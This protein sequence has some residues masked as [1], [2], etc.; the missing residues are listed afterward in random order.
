MIVAPISDMA[1]IKPSK[2]GAASKLNSFLMYKTA[3]AIVALSHPC[4]KF[5]TVA[6]IATSTAPLIVNPIFLFQL[7]DQLLR[8]RSRVSENSN[9]YQAAI[10]AT[11]YGFKRTKKEDTS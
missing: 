6:A 2:V 9:H 11:K 4:S 10:R 5:P 1:T 8:E 3:P 7:L